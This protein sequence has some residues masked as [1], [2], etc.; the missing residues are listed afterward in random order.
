M[1]VYFDERDTWV[2]LYRDKKTGIRY[3]CLLP[4]LVIRWQKRGGP[5]ARGSEDVQ[6]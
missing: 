1:K 4:C 2:G 6:V 3:L 5:V